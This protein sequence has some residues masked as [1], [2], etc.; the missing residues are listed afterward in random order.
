MKKI[1]LLLFIIPIIGFSQNC[2]QF[3]VNMYDSAGDGWNGD[4]LSILDSLGNTVFA[5]TLSSGSFGVDSVCLQEDSIVSANYCYTILCGGGINQ[6]E[7]SW[8]F[9]DANGVVLFSGGA[10]DSSLFCLP[11]YCTPPFESFE[12]LPISWENGVYTGFG[13]TANLPWVRSSGSTPT[14]NT[15]PSGTN[16]GNGSYYMYL[17]CGSFSQGSYATLTAN[18]VNPVFYN[19]LHLSFQ[20]HMWGAGIGELKVEVSSDGGS[21]WVTEWSK[22]GSQGNWWWQEHVDLSAYTSSIMVRFVGVVGINN[23][24]DIAIDVVLFHDPPSG[25]MD[26]F[27]D[28]YDPAAVIDDGSCTYSNCTFLILNMYDS[29]GD[30]WNG[31]WFTLTSSDGTEFY[32]TTLWQWPNG[33]SATETICVPDDCYSITCNGGYWQSEVSWTLTDTNGI[34][35]KSGGAPY[36]GSLC[37]PVAYGCTDPLASNYDP[38]ADYNDGSCMYPPMILSAIVSDISCNGQNDGDINLTV[39]GGVAPFTYLWSNGST[40]EDINNVAADSFSVVVTDD[41]GQT[42]SASFY[43]SEPDSLLTDYVIID[44]SGVGINDGAIYS[45]TNGGTLPYNYYWLSSFI[46]DTTQHIVGIPAGGYT[47]YI[48][49][50]NGCFNFVGL[51]V[52]IDS[53]SNGCT[54]PLAFNY[55]PNAITDDGSCVY[56]GCTDPNAANYNSLATIDD[57]SCFYCAPPNSY[58]TMLTTDWTTDTKAGISWDNMNDNCNMVWKYYVRYREV[59]TQTWITKSAGVGNGLCNSGL[60]TNSKTLQN[61]V[62]GT[63][64]EYKMKAFYCGGGQSGYSLASQFTTADDCPAMAY[65][66]VSTFNN[67]HQKVRFNWN[68]YGPYVFARVVLRVDNPGTSWQ[69]VGGFGIYYPTL[70]VNKFGLQSGESYRAQGR[71]FCDSN[72]TSYRSTWTNPVF[73]TQPGSIRMSGGHTIANLDVYPNPSRDLFNISFNSDIQQDLSVRIL[74]VVGAEV[75]IEEKQNFIG[76]YTKQISLDDYGKGIYFLEIETTNGVINKKLILQ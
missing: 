18:C 67:N 72:I 42:E 27:A 43:I 71:L 70:S 69:T 28:N 33:S 2:S 25:C 59:G 6:S 38:S 65:L 26:Q 12:S 52:G 23:A 16:W 54:D 5:T 39:N 47:S 7:V 76:E 73:W 31:N 60:N 22:S 46:S 66:N 44:A 29:F 57:G 63:T 74:S 14:P 10:P 55:D 19:N 50:D 36:G 53:S 4:T 37:L 58:P 20:H 75:Y 15:G 64:Y 11:H 41:N 1:L 9:M 45:F 24:G 8:D 48:I 62:S 68:S 21:T 40:N 56:V 49:D 3:Y 35:L 30:G 61:L 17:E 34:V 13:Q 51:V 32:T